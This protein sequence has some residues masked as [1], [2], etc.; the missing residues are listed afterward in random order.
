MQPVVK[1]F[2]ATVTFAWQF[3]RGEQTASIR[4]RPNVLE[5]RR[6]VSSRFDG[7]MYAAEKLK[8]ELASKNASLY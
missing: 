2:L 5:D 7:A 3:V 1:N 6:L 8:A 4:W